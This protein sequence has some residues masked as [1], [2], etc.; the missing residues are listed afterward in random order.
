MKSSKPKRVAPVT[1][2]N[3][4]LT[5]S[6][7][8]RSPTT[9]EILPEP[10]PAQDLYSLLSLLNQGQRTTAI[11]NIPD[12][13]GRTTSSEADNP[14]FNRVKND[15]RLKAES[16]RSEINDSNGPLATVMELPSQL[17]NSQFTASTSK[18]ISKTF[19]RNQVPTLKN[20][21]NSGEASQARA[22]Q[23]E[24]LS[25]T[26]QLC[27]PSAPL[28]YKR[29]LDHEKIRKLK[30][31]DERVIVESQMADIEFPSREAQ[32]L[33]FNRS[34][35]SQ[36]P[37]DLSPSERTRSAYQSQFVR[38]PSNLQ[39]LANKELAGDEI[40]QSQGLNASLQSP[41]ML[42]GQLFKKFRG[43]Q[44]E[45]FVSEEI[46][47]KDSPPRLKSQVKGMSIG[48]EARHTVSKLAGADHIVPGHPMNSF[49]QRMNQASP[50]LGTKP[51]LSLNEITVSSLPEN[52]HEIPTFPRDPVRTSIAST[53]LSKPLDGILRHFSPQ[54][55]TDGYDK[56]VKG[57]DLCWGDRPHPVDSLQDLKNDCLVGLKDPRPSLQP[58][59]GG[60]RTLS[61]EE[62]CA[63]LINQT[64]PK[65][66]R[67]ADRVAPMPEASVIPLTISP[68][69]SNKIETDQVP[70]SLLHATASRPLSVAFSI[71]PSNTAKDPN[72]IQEK[73]ELS[74]SKMISNRI[75]TAE[76]QTKYLALDSDSLPGTSHSPDNRPY[77]DIVSI[78]VS[79]VGIRQAQVKAFD[80]SHSGG[81]VLQVSL[82]N[83][84]PPKARPS[85]VNAQIK[86]P[87]TLESPPHQSLSETTPF[88]SPAVEHKA[89]RQ[90]TKK[91]MLK[92]GSS[93][94]S[95]SV[96]ANLSTAATVPLSPKKPEGLA[97]SIRPRLLNVTDSLVPGPGAYDQSTNRQVHGSVIGGKFSSSPRENQEKPDAG[98]PWM[99]DIRGKFKGPF[100][101]FG[102][103][104]QR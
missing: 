75:P 29:A 83:S 40:Q 68:S 89:K 84:T 20:S 36:S 34:S 39:Q 35:P 4:T 26:S 101:S 97:Y 87:Y 72:K 93:S 80:T 22:N 64:K 103:G 9:K 21:I 33:Q 99:Y 47:T 50:D 85:S 6:S 15:E 69:V 59:T 54:L 70:L 45:K 79:E 104:L 81:E 82:F 96:S 71:S 42:E 90:P 102:G 48:S 8:K 1:L 16:P 52:S 56:S 51:N 19:A 3:R 58:N 60:A 17:D 5:S 94:H 53:N 2:E 55:S 12:M 76:K 28:P 57:L 74:P 30:G 38:S 14:I 88:K 10:G 78:P 91:L 65:P 66:S 63:N 27:G 25:T 46:A 37:Q 7:N 100:W 31:I 49:L 61:I 95:F 23:A 98:G 92:F 62:D 41:S 67:N 13:G 86:A 24:V 77:K 11:E 43:K 44:D 18:E 32:N 73:C